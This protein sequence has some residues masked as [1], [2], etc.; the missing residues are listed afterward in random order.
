MKNM[1]GLL[2]KEEAAKIL[3][4]EQSLDNLPGLKDLVGD[5]ESERILAQQSK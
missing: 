2:G 4:S 5:N 3:A 1:E